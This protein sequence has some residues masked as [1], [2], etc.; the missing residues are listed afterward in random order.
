MVVTIAASDSPGGVFSLTPT[1]LTLSEESAPSGTI[2]VQRTG[3][4]LTQVTI[5]WEALYT[6][7]QIHDTAII[8]ILGADRASL[9]FPVGVTSIDIN[10]TLQPNSVSVPMKSIVSENVCES[11]ESNHD[12]PFTLKTTGYIILCCVC[13]FRCQP[14]ERCS[15][16]VCSQTTLALCLVQTQRP[17]SQ[18]WPNSPLSSRSLLPTCKTHPSID[19]D[20]TL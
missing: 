14:V 20:I 6:D 9:T 5:Q 2:T 7:G 12:E 17:L 16:C 15:R 18:C 11:S 19:L 1:S 4:A 13:V 8:S 10:L 3:G